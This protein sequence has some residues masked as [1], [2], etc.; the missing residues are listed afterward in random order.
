MERE[1]RTFDA[2]ITVEQR[3]GEPARIVGHAAV[4]NAFSEDLGGFRERI[5]PGAFT[6]SIGADDVRALINH[7]PNLVLGRNRAGTLSL[8]EDERGLAIRIVPPDTS[9]AR[10]LLVSMTRGDITQMSFVFIV[11]RGGAS[12]SKDD[13]GAVRSL[14]AVRLLDVSPVTFPAYPQT[15]VA[16]RELRTWTEESAIPED[17][18]RVRLLR[19][20]L[21]D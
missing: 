21:I 15:D 18:W 16:L 9:Y 7:D 3:D 14:T 6:E 4:F 1:F 2:D 20:R 12:W 11:K 19:R 17:P 13:G 8:S 5:A 10:D